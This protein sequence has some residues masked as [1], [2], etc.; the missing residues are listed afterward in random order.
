MFVRFAFV[1]TRCDEIRLSRCFSNARV[2]MNAT[3]TSPP[4]SH[5]TLHNP[6]WFAVKAKTL[7]SLDVSV[8]NKS[9]SQD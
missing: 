8:S 4:K 1:L 9:N 5:T 3:P 7:R 6:E 2:G